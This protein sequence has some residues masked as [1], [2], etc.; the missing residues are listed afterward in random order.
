MFN[1]DIHHRRSIRWTGYDYR[2]AGA[3]F[4][5]VCTRRKQPVLGR[6]ENETIHLHPYG[7]I[8]TEEWHRTFKLRP[9]CILDEF[10]VMPNHVHAIILLTDCVASP[11]V[12]PTFAQPIPESLSTLVGAFKSAATRRVNRHR[13]ERNWPPV[14]VWQRGFHERVIRNEPELLAKRRYIIENP[15][16]WVAKQNRDQS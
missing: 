10:I 14:K 8:V 12:P 5:T 2:N 1:P 16:R 13:A 9:T 6:F 7:Q 3:Y 15:A 4:I 11:H